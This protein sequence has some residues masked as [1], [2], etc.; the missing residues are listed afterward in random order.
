MTGWIGLRN[1]LRDVVRN[2]LR[3]FL[4]NVLGMPW[5]S[6]TAIGK[7]PRRAIDAHADLVDSRRA[8]VSS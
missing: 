1:P 4:R 5:N 6:G 7:G 3:N 2:A 8:I